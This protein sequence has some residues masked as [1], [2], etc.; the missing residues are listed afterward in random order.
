MSARRDNSSI[1]FRSVLV[2]F[3]SLQ[4]FPFDFRGG[5]G[6]NGGAG[7]ERRR[8]PTLSEI[9]FLLRR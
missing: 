6:G 2:G 5:G 4:I 8:T 9:F 1:D 3:L 7:D